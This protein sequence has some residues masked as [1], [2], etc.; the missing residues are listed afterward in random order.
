MDNSIQCDIHDYFEH[1][2][3][4]RL[5]VT[6]KLKD[7]SSVSGIAKDIQV[8]DGQECLIIEQHE[9]T[10]AYPLINIAELEFEQN[11]VGRKVKVN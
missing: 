1:V 3:V 11:G 7:G 2:C 10:N 9:K 8:Q 4:L 5:T 6:L